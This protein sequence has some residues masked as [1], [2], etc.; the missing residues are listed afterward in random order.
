MR[1]SAAPS[2]GNAAACAVS[3]SPTANPTVAKIHDME[4]PNSTTNM[5]AA[6]V[7]STPVWMRQPTRNPTTIIKITTKTLRVASAVVRPVST[8]D[9]AMGSAWNRSIR[10]DFTSEASPIA[11]AM[12]PNVTVCTKMPGIR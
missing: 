7:G 12:A 4:K 9:R 8:A 3:G 5:P 2:T 1:R 6:I 10:P 11:V